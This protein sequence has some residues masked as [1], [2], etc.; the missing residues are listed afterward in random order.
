MTCAHAA[1]LRAGHQTRLT[2]ST[3]VTAPAGAALKVWATALPTDT[4]PA[5]NSAT[6]TVTV[7]QS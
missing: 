3:H 1:S 7:A 6:T 4:T 2:I 5:N